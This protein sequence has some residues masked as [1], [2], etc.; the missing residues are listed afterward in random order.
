MLCLL[1]LLLILVI[2]FVESNR[3]LNQLIYALVV[4]VVLVGGT[5]ISQPKTTES[6]IAGMQFGRPTP[7]PMGSSQPANQTDSRTFNLTFNGVDK[8]YL[9]KINDIK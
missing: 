5:M 8:K 7:V 2:I 6:F 4:L 1:G 9:N 3:N